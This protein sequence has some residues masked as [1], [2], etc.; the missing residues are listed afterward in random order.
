MYDNGMTLLGF[1]TILHR[2]CNNNI[3]KVIRLSQSPVGEALAI[4]RLPG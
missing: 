2:K 1:K 4:L 3:L